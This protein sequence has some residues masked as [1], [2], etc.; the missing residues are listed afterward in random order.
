MTKKIYS[1]AEIEVSWEPDLCIHS[2]KCVQGS[3]KVFNPRRRPWI[4]LEHENTERILAI[5]ANCPSGALKARRLNVG[6]TGRN[7]EGNDD[8]VGGALEAQG[9]SGAEAQADPRPVI[10]ASKNGPLRIEFACVV[11]D[12]E[13]NVIREVSKASL[14]RCGQS[15]NK[16][17]CDGTHSRVN[18]EG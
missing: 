8:R 16:P 15:S 10:T 2:A 6:E 7:E 18:F 9:R 1:T 5:V 11:K 3:F 12:A 17:F 13:G 4:E 14:C